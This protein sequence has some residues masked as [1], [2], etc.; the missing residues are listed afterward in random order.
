MKKFSIEDAWND[1]TLEG[2]L[3][4]TGGMS[5]GSLYIT[6]V[7]EKE[8]GEL[9]Y[10]APKIP[11]PYDK[12]GYD[13][14]RDI[15][16]ILVYDKIDGTNVFQFQYHDAEEN[17]YVSYK[18]RR[19]PNLSDEFLE[20]WKEI[21]DIYPEIRDLP[22]NNPNLSFELYG[23]KNKH[24]VRYDV[25]LDTA[26]LF[27]IEKDGTVLAPENLNCGSVPYPALMTTINSDS[28]LAL[29][30]Q[31]LRQ[32]LQDNL[33]VLNEDINE[34]EIEGIEGV[35]W[36]MRH[37]YGASMFKCKPEA[38]QNFAFKVAEGIPKH[39]I[40]ATIQNAFEETEQVNFELVFNL[41][42]EEYEEGAIYKKERHI[43]RLIG[44]MIFEHG[45]EKR[46]SDRYMELNNKNEMFNINKDKGLVMRQFAEDLVEWGYDKKSMGKCFQT[47]WRDFGDE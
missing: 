1:N 13:F 2:Y 3:K 38:V 41:L 46:I 8:T 47:I 39:A 26:I 29:E 42:K 27:G 23:A 28:D 34:F 14:G 20:M 5:Y 12:D 6:R 24:S 4:M 21:L 25:R 40:Y 22:D 9:I 44:G 16:D 31:K 33:V 11:Y 18:T 32:S 17:V 19:M 30:Y 45:L 7:N 35:V 43:R 10:C 36:Y 37:D 15:N